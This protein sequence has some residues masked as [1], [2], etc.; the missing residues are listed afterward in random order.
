MLF[1]DITAAAAAGWFNIYNTA[2]VNRY[3]YK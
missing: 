2:Q 3:Y 1:L